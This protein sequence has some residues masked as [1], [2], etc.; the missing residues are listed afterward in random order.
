MRSKT[1]LFTAA[2]MAGVAAL[3][4]TACNTVDDTWNKITGDDTPYAGDVPPQSAQQQPGALQDQ[5]Q[6]MAAQPGMMQ[7]MQNGQMQNQQMTMQQPVQAPASMQPNMYAQ[8]PMAQPGM[9]PMQQGGQMQPQPMQQAY[10][11]PMNSPYA[12]N[13]AAVPP[14]PMASQLPSPQQVQMARADLGNDNRNATGYLRDP[15]GS[16][17]PMAQS[18]PMQQSM[19][20]AQNTMPPMPVQPSPIQ[21][22]AS[23]MGIPA[24]MPL[25]TSATPN[26]NS[27]VGKVVQTGQVQ[28][29]QNPSPM[30]A[31][32]YT[33]PS[34]MMT[35]SDQL[36]GLQQTAP[37]RYALAPVAPE[38][39]MGGFSLASSLV[40]PQGNE[41]VSMPQYQELRRVAS[42][43]TQQ[44]GRIR[45]V[46][47]GDAGSSQQALQHATTAAAYLVDLGVP[48]N[49]IRVKVDT[50]SATP[51]MGTPASKTDIFLETPANH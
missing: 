25:Q 28:V 22:N 36:L 51:A 46:S 42:Q 32:S 43:Y 7:P 27:P 34:T 31:P 23:S 41:Q 2:L 8:Q 11:Q 14:R 21:S 48:A 38:S 19:Q 49:A 44:P 24:G 16:A 50:A 45:V 20:M 10:Q 26:L 15:N 6:Q 5:N 40:Y 30:M 12:P 33:G 9:M 29:T 13:L 35:S 37:G 39:P 1:S 4:L 47:Y 18:M 3:A 17:M